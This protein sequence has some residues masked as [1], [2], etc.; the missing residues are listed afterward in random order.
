MNR[1]I[2]MKELDFLLQDINDEERTEALNYYQDYFDEAGIENEQAIISELGDPSRVAAMIKD[3]LKGTFDD[4]IEVGN[5]GFSNEDY[6]HHYAIIDSKSTSSSTTKTLKE[7]WHDM[8]SRD[9]FILILILVL[10]FVPLSFP[11]FGVFGGIFGVGFKIALAFAC[12][13]FGFWIITFVLYVVAIA[14]IVSGV[15][16][17][18]TLT[19]AG[20]IYMGIGCILIAFAKIFGRIASWFFK[21]CIPSLID[22]IST[23]FNRIFGNRGVES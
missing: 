9:K 23:L 14:L 10:A 22:S 5:Q 13:F 18:F 19:G 17:L 1:E 4:H 6:E 16:H 2:F 15:L 3:G 7:K 11:L 21:E 20:L 12:V 8:V